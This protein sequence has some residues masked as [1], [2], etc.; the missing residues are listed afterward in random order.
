MVRLDVIEKDLPFR[1]RFPTLESLEGVLYCES[2]IL[3][4]RVNNEMKYS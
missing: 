2:N 4:L 3:G 1:L